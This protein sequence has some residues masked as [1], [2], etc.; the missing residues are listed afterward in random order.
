MVYL[1]IQD[2]YNQAHSCSHKP[3]ISTLRRSSQDILEV[4][5]QLGSGYN[6]PGPRSKDRTVGA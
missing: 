5:V 6:Y 4:E 3:F 2:S 1:E